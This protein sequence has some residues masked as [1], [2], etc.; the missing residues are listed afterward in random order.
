MDITVR[1]LHVMDVDKL[2]SGIVESKKDGPGIDRH[3]CVV[4]TSNAR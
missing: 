1:E 2:K 3:Q 4:N